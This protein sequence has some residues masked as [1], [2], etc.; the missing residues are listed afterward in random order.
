MNWQT[1]LGV[2]WLAGVWATVLR[3]KMIWQEENAAYR[4]ALVIVSIPSILTL[5]VIGAVLTLFRLS[6]AWVTLTI[7][8]EEP[9]L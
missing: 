9:K 5:Q 4:L 6:W 3:P 1:F 2:W 8:G 7:K